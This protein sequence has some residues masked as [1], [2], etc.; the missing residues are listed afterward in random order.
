MIRLALAFAILAGSVESQSIKLQA[1]EIATLLSGNT[2]AGVW[3]DV[4]YRQY[5]GDDGV[6][7][8][9]QGGTEILRGKWRVDAELNEYQSIWS[10]NVEWAGWYVMKFSGNWYWVSKT[11]PP[12]QFEVLE[13]EQ[14]FTD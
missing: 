10:N 1:D 13:G 12:T 8:F 3:D 4:L 7:V 11:T 6:T 9:S 5:F 2:A 14:L